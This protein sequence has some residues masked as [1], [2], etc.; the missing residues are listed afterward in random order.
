MLPVLR[1]SLS[2][3][4]TKEEVSIKGLRLLDAQVAVVVVVVVEVAE[5]LTDALA[6]AVAVIFVVV[7]ACDVDVELDEL[8]C[9]KS[10]A[11]ISS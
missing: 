9:R 7:G 4:I 2:S 1:F 6:E 5:R 3:R 11:R 10:F 8:V